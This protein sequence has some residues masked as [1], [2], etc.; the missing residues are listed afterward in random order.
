MD[1]EYGFCNFYG[2]VTEDFVLVE[3]DATSLGTQLIIFWWQEVPSQGQ[4]PSASDAASYQRRIDSSRVI[5]ILVPY[6]AR[7]FLSS[8][9]TIS[10]TKKSV[11]FPCPHIYP[12]TLY[13]YIYNINYPEILTFQLP[14]TGLYLMNWVFKKTQ[15]KRNILL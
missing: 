5:N 12:F 13:I 8:W 10:F 2:T 11:N 9:T 6:K 4:N 14:I 3:G 1:N 15:M 7:H